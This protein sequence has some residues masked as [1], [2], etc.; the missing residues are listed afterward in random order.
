MRKADWPW[1]RVL[2]LT[3]LLQAAASAIDD[4]T[5]P[6]VALQFD[7]S[8][9]RYVEVP[10]SS[11]FSVGDSGL[12]VAAWVRPDTFE[13]ANTEPQG[14]DPQCQY[15]HWLGKGED[16]RQEWTFRIYR[17]DAVAC[18]GSPPNRSKRISFYVFAPEG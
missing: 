8:Q 14:R 18:S 10:T 13:F 11:D 17:D 1:L 7:G 3:L 9:T 15:V 4:P 16:G 2:L 5:P 6:K 12:T